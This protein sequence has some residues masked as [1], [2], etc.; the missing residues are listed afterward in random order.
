MIVFIEDLDNLRERIKGIDYSIMALISQRVNL[1]LQIGKLK[2]ERNLPVRN[3]QVEKQVFERIKGYS[4]EFQLDFDFTKEV[5]K[6]V[7][8]QS[9]NA[10]IHDKYKLISPL[11]NKRALIIGGS[12]KMG[13]WFVRFLSSTGYDIEIVDPQI[14]HS[15]RG[16]TEIPQ[17]LNSFDY[18]FV[19]VPLNKMREVLELLIL[20]KPAAIIVEIASLKSSIIEIVEK[21]NNQGI[22]L[23]SIHPMFGPDVTDLSDRNL[24]VCTGETNKDWISSEVNNIFRE[25]MVNIQSL[26]LRDHDKKMLYSLGLSHFM[27]ILNGYILSGSDI[28]FS[29]LK[30]FA[31]TT[32]NNQ[33]ITTQEVYNENPELY[34]SIQHIN[35][36]QDQLYSEIQSRTKDL[37]EII[38]NDDEGK[39][40]KIM[41]KGH[42]YLDGGNSD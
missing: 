18:I 32:F 21:A 33:I 20:R 23:I 14:K 17:K 7:I 31:G 24:V 4:D 30:R 8:S 15:E 6:H 28:D 13:T 19:C 2:N 35:A 37:I 16:Y 41:E 22:K 3:Y 36:Y 25:T 27:N 38:K 29:D 42:N 34:F 39:F 12:G 5:Y 1:A 11:L 40:L 10:Q 9:V 26:E